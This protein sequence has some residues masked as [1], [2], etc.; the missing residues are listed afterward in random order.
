MRNECPVHL[1]HA[2]SMLPDEVAA[3]RAELAAFGSRARPAGS[4][5]LVVHEDQHEGEAIAL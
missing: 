1:W 5:Y 3:G 4:G 2:M